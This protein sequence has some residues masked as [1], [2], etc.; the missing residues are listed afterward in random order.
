MGEGAGSPPPL[1]INPRTH[2]HTHTKCKCTHT[3]SC[4]ELLS[5]SGTEIHVRYRDGLPGPRV[6]PHISLL[7]SLGVAGLPV[8]LHLVAH[9]LQQLHDV[10]L[11]ARILELLDSVLVSSGV[12]F[13]VTSLWV[14][15]KKIFFMK[16]LME[17][18]DK[19]L[20][21]ILYYIIERLSFLEVKIY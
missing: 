13:E 20:F 11:A 6:D 5:P 17:P 19:I 7:A 8:V 1:C 12:D 18:L 21:F 3:Y 14:R 10:C 15:K 4:L 9:G 16:F 2:T